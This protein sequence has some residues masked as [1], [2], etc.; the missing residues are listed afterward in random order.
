MR[1]RN[2]E[3]GD[4][5]RHKTARACLGRDRARA[6]HTAPR[7]R[8]RDPPRLPAR[9]ARPRRRRRCRHR[10]NFTA[11][12]HG[13]SGTRFG[14]THLYYFATP[15]IFARRREPFDDDLFQRFAAF[16]VTGFATT[17]AAVENRP[18]AVFFPSSAALDEPRREL[19]E[20]I[21]AKTAGEAV[22]A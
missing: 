10:R 19:T 5:A 1:R 18:L 22:A 2:V 13:V 17:C 3:G 20:Y 21:A 12:R 4:A 16:Y 7:R 8:T 6:W 15:R 14:A 9:R 11:C